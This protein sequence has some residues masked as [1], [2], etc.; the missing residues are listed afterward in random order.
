M[1]LFMRKANTL[2]YGENKRSGMTVALKKNF[3]HDKV[4]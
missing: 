4:L 1:M 3:N 2:I